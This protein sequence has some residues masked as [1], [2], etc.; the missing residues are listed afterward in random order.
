MNPGQA[1]R[2]EPPV[3]DGLFDHTHWS[4]VLRAKADSPTALNSLCRTYRSPLLAWLRCRGEKPEDAEDRVQGFFEHLLRHD[5][6]RD[7][8]REKGRFRTFLLAAFRNYLCDQHKHASA[9]K[10]GGGQVPQSLEAT[11]GE[12][13]LLHRPASACPAPDQEY[14]RA[15]AAA[16]LAS[17]L[18][19]LA[20]ECAR[21]GHAALCAALKPLSGWRP[22]A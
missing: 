6:L 17:A 22:S 11:D 19:R 13:E 5:F 2:V 9:A 10:R 16:L 15:W 1:V 8:A 7:V 14:D 18:Q 20:A 4:T 3:S 21:T 12:G